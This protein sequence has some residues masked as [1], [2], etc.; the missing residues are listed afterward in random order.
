MRIGPNDSIWVVVDAG[1]ESEQDDILFQTT[2]RGLDLQFKGGLTMDRNPTLFTDRKEA[3]IEAYGRLTAQAIA[4][5]G[6]GAKLEE[7]RYIEILDGDGKL[8]FEAGC[9]KQ[10]YS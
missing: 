7:V 5:A 10:S 4:N 6:I 3:E 8:L 9:L 1:P 2:L